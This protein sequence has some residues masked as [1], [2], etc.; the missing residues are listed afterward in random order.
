MRTEEETYNPSISNDID[1]IMTTP[2]E[3]RDKLLC[4]L[5]PKRREVFKT[6]WCGHYECDTER[7]YLEDKSDEDQESE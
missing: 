5:Y 4:C 7:I 6:H 2:H 1:V 3:T